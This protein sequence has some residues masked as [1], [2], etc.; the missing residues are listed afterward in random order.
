MLTAGSIRLL[1][2]GP[3]AWART[4][5]VYRA[6]AEL[7]PVAGPD[8]VVF[9][10][11]LQP[12]LSHG[13]QQFA[14]EALDLAACERLGWRVV[15]RPLPGGAEY[16]DVNQLLVQWMGPGG[17]GSGAAPFIAGV[18]STLRD[19]GVTAEY[20]GR[21]QFVTK[22]AC[23]GTLA[24]GR[25]DSAFV[26]LG[27]LYLSYD[28]QNLARVSFDTRLPNT[29]SVWAESPRP[30]APEMLQGLLIEQLAFQMGRPIERDTPRLPETRA[31]RRIEQELLGI[32]VAEFLQG[33]AGP[34]EH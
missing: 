24:A 31:A 11:S 3:T 6:T 1:N 18:L 9:A 27:C 21:G 28:P 30:L 25:L 15:R 10:Q 34:A 29:T 22:G 4:Q 2:L 7:M 33:E 19:L 16:C 17:A 20:D 14:S 8:T 26:L 5:S 13:V 23:L 12:Y 32:E